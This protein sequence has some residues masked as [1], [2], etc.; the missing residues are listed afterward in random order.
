MGLGGKLAACVKSCVC[1]HVNL[2][3]DDPCV[4]RKSRGLCATLSVSLFL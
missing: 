2:T 1:P 3:S 4:Y